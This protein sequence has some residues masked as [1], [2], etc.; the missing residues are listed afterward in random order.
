MVGGGVGK[1]FWVWPED[2]RYALGVII[3]ALD[4]SLRDDGRVLVP[5]VFCWAACVRGEALPFQEGFPSDCFVG[6][7]PWARCDEEVSLD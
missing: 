7:L 6:L 2:C 1:F 3:P 5:A 4:S